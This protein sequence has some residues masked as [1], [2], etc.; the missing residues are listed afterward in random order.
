MTE[1]ELKAEA[2]RMG[3]SLI[4]R[5]KAERFLPCLCGKNRRERWYTNNEDWSVKLV[6]Y[7]CGLSVTGKNEKDAKRKWNEYMRGAE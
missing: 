1:E 3:Y 4:K 6:C 5:P 7:Y 2:K